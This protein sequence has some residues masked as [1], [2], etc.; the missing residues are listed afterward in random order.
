LNSDRPIPSAAGD[1]LP[2]RVRG[3]EPEGVRGAEPEGVHARAPMRALADERVGGVVFALL[4]LGC[5]AAL[6]ITQ[7]LKHTPTLVQEPKLTPVIAPAGA[8]ELK[9]E[10]IAFKFAEADDVT[11][12]IERVGGGDVATLVRDLP[13]P[14][15]KIISLRWNGREGTAR[16]YSVLRRANGYTTLLPL[17]RGAVAPAGEYR[18]RLSVSKQNRSLYLPRNFTLVKP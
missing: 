4:V 9:E 12:T 16:H 3:A 14:R 15:Y 10:H 11:V 18:V 6:L 2:G 7:R 17:T 5:F 8:G 13:V 1:P